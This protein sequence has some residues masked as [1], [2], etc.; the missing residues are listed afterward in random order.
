[1][2]V[3]SPFLYFYSSWTNV[4]NGSCDEPSL[5]ARASIFGSET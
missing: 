3:F 5:A 4:V 2:T 1:L